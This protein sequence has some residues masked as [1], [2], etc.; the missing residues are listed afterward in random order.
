MFCDD[1][2]DEIPVGSKITVKVI[3]DT[4]SLTVDDVIPELYFGNINHNDE[5][6]EGASLPMTFSE[7]T[8]NGFYLYTGQVLCLKSGQFGF[9]VRLMPHNIESVRKFDPELRGIWMGEKHEDI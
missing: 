7:K 4:G 8:H 6:S 3:I 1:N 2:V 5:I 9:T